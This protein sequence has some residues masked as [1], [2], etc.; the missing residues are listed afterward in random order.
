[1]SRL[2]R[3]PSW[4][5]GLFAALALLAGLAAPAPAAALG[6]AEIFGPGAGPPAEFRTRASNGF[7]VQVR[8]GRG[9]VTLSASG[10]T[11]TA[12]YRVRGRASGRRIVA[13]F[14]KRGRIDVTFKPSHRK[15]LET[16]PNGC[17]GPPH[18]TQWGVFAGTIRFRG[19]RGFTRLHAGRVGGRT[20]SHQRWKCKRRHRAQHSAAS[21]AN[22]DG[23]VILDISG[24]RRG[25]EVSAFSAER[26]ET[27]GLTAF[28]AS[29]HERRGR[30]GI[31]RSSFEIAHQWNFTF[32]DALTTA[33]VM[34]PA[35]FAGRATF[36]HLPGEPVSWAGSLSL[37]LPGTK[38]FSLVGPRYHPRLYEIGRDG[39][40]KPGV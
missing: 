13:N 18:V 8:G 39:I 28:F 9:R 1:M 21:S 36:E 33:T 15:R 26:G 19:E 2:L 4:G 3:E 35:P 5:A 29:L 7:S 20:H 16:P 32:D 34:P 6:F 24:P 22:Q 27:F 40:A 12:S 31:V 37:A 25:L 11:G 10:P 17:K 14:G 38:R 23:P 30:M